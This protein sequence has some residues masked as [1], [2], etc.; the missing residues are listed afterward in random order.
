MTRV[1]VVNGVVNTIN[2]WYCDYF[3]LCLTEDP[4]FFLSVAGRKFFGV[5]WHDKTFV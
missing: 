3:C 5:A 1:G 4:H 2:D